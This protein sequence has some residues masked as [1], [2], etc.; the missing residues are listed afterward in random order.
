MAYLSSSLLASLVKDLLYHGLLRLARTGKRQST[1]LAVSVVE[2]HLSKL[3]TLQIFPN[4]TY[5]L[6][7]DLDQV[8]IQHTL[9]PLLED[10][11][12]FLVRHPQTILHNIVGL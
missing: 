10:V 11:A 4:R 6:L 7:G 3:V 12:H 8:G 5:D 1:C 2:V 9:V